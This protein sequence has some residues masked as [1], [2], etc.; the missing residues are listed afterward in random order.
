VLSTLHRYATPARTAQVILV[1]GMIGAV[2]LE[3]V[4]ADLSLF[5]VLLALWVAWPFWVLFN[6][7]RAEQT[8]ASGA[9][10]VAGAVLLN[11]TALLGYRPG[12]LRS[13]STAGLIFFFL[14]LWQLIGA[15]ILRTVAVRLARRGAPRPSRERRPFG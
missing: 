7:T 8:F 14:P 11:V 6:G 13:S 10:Y 2:A 12:S 1:L 9:L 5:S 4:A 3:F 15:V